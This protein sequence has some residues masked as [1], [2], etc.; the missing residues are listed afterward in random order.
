MLLPARWFALASAR[1]GNRS[2]ASEPGA[3]PRSQQSFDAMVVRVIIAIV[4]LFA[5]VWAVDQHFIT[6]TEFNLEMRGI[7]EQLRAVSKRLGIKQPV[8]STEKPPQE[9]P[10]Q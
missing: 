6:R 9:D 7:H 3:P 4:A 8:A 5:A 10:D 2:K 1:H